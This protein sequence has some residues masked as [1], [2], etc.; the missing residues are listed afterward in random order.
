MGTLLQRSHDRFSSGLGHVVLLG[1]LGILGVAL[2]MG[3][4]F[5]EPAPPSAFRFECSSDVECEDG[6]SCA[7]GLCQ[8]PCGG[9]T[10]EPCSQEV[11]LNGYCSSVCSIADDNCSSPQT[12]HSLA[13]PGEEPGSTGVCMVSCGADA[14]CPEGQLCYEDLGLCVATCMTTDECAA[15]EECVTGFCVPTGG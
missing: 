12:C 11:C 10:D 6:L 4:C 3:A 7:S 14:P 1:T 5:I 2:G 15:G 8:Q 9:E 13:F